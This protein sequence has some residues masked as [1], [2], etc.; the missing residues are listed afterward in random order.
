MHRRTEIVQDLPPGALFVGAAAVA[1]VDDHQVEKVGRILPIVGGHIVFGVELVG[2]ALRDGLVDGEEDV[3]VGRHPAAALFDLF[4]VDADDVFLQ[5]VEGVES[6]IGQDVSVGQEEDLGASGAAVAAP[7]GCEEPIDDL[8]GDVGLARTRRQGQ[9]HPVPA[10]GDRFE[11]LVH[12]VSLI[13]AGLHRP[14]EIVGLLEEALFGRGE[15]GVLSLEKLLRRGKSLYPPPPAG[16]QVVFVDL[17]AVGGI[18]YIDSQFLRVVDGLLK[19]FEGVAV[20]GFGFDD[21]EIGVFID[22]QI[23]HIVAL[24]PRPA[25]ELAPVG[26]VVLTDNVVFRPTAC[27]ETG[28]DQFGA[29][30]CFGVSHKGLLSF[31]MNVTDFNAKSL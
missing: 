15:C 3:G 11:G 12:G 8:K 7:A 20:F 23:V 27:F 24:P 22:Q 16:S 31:I 18:D 30:V 14:F 25:D 4:A 21:G 1:L 19:P 9:Q 6:L 17:T 13:V 2:F 28:I 29:G 26:E 10:L 5:R